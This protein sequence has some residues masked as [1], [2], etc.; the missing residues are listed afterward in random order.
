MNTSQLFKIT[1]YVLLSFV[2][3]AVLY[4][5]SS[6]IFL[7]ML[8]A[9]LMQVPIDGS[10]NHQLVHLWTYAYR[11]TI[12]LALLFLILVP[13]TFLPIFKERLKTKKYIRIIGILWIVGFITLSYAHY[14][15]WPTKPDTVNGYVEYLLGEYATDVTTFYEHDLRGFIDRDTAFMIAADNTVLE[16]IIAL[17]NLEPIT[18]I[19][20]RLK[21]VSPHW[22]PN[23]PPDNALL[24]ISTDFHYMNEGPMEHFI[25]LYMTLLHTD[26]MCMKIIT[27]DYGFN[28]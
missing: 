18:T 16:K 6:L 5:V 28:A 19:P 10:M 2:G 11:V 27:S 20:D 4:Y 12:I 7:I 24:Y 23:S 8:V 21:N 15:D 14:K 22:W 3:I 25:S 9:G 17:R 1:L 26:Y 13:G